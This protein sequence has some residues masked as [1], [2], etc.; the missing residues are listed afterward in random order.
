MDTSLNLRNKKFAIYGLGTTG[1]S[2]IN[3]F[4]KNGFKNY[5]FWDDDKNLKKNGV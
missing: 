1:T 4:N 3:Y 5:I 2:V